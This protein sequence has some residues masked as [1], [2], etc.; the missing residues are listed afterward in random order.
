M[1]NDNDLDIW[2]RAAVH[3]HQERL[4]AEERADRLRAWGMDMES[5]LYALQ[6]RYPDRYSDY[7]PGEHR[8]DHLLPGDA[9]EHQDEDS[10]A[11]R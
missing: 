4:E 2:R 6:R 8:R 3:H 1:M 10:E 11:Q 9:P 5:M 7:S